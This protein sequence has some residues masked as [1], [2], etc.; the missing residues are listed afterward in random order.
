M[1]ATTRNLAIIH[2]NNSE[3]EQSVRMQQR[4]G[5]ALSRGRNV[6]LVCDT[7]MVRRLERMVFACLATHE[8]SSRFA[9][10]APDTN[11]FTETMPRTLRERLQ[12]FSTEDAAYQWLDPNPDDEEG[13]LMDLSAN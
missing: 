10:V 3:L 7:P 6:V 1:Q 11:E 2:F 12:V 8:Q 9:I 13:T 4:I 5:N